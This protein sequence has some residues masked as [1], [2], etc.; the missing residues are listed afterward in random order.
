MNANRAVLLASLLFATIASAQIADLSIRISGA[1]PT[2]E[3]HEKFDYSATLV[4]HGPDDAEHVEVTIGDSGWE[5]CLWPTDIGTLPA[6]AT[7]TFACR[8]EAAYEPYVHELEAVVFSAT[9]DPN[10][11]NNRATSLVYVITPP[12]LEVGILM[13]RLVAPGIGFPVEISYA[14]LSRTAASGV[15]ITVTPQTRVTQV[16]AECEIEGTSATCSVGSIG[17]DEP[18]RRHLVLYVEAP[19]ASQAAFTITA[20]ITAAEEDPVRDNNTRTAS[21]KTFLTT[22][23][24]NIADS[25]SGSLRAAIEWANA[26]CNSAEGCL[27]AFRVPPAGK[28]WQTIRTLTPLPRI[29]G[30]TVRVDGTTQTAYFGDTN[31]AGPEIEV[32]GSA[33]TSGNGF[34]IAA[35]AVLRGLTINGFP[36]SGVFILPDRPG[37]A[38]IEKNYIGTDPTG[39]ISV[40]NQRGVWIEVPD[41]STAR[42]RDNTISG[43][44]RSAVYIQRGQTE[45]LRNIIGLNGTLTAGVGNGASGVYVSPNAGLARIE[46]NYIGFNEHFGIAIAREAT[47]VLAGRNSFQAN[48]QMA[49]DWGFDGLP[50]SDPAPIPEIARVWFAEGVT[51][52]EVTTPELFPS[53]VISPEIVVFA[54][55][56]PDPS[57]FG[58][59]QYFLGSGQIPF[60]KD[61]FV[62]VYPGDLRGKWVTAVATHS[63]WYGFA[64][65]HPSATARALPLG[66]IVTS[67]FSR[68][69]EVK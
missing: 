68:A 21:S 24:E 48:W 60:G 53:S 18:A 43:N 12:D 47:K 57:G 26:S 25:G 32:N 42:V 1:P 30:Q 27:V 22:W 20:R 36:D 17:V 45:V 58:E 40:A 54:N 64:Q 9:D 31:L 23:V 55:D 37:S 63:N 46:E 44:T 2:V 6:F 62:L 11:E 50:T 4:N 29:V 59:G 51:S 8:S 3:P 52:I 10:E 35:D 41:Q 38:T 65:G 49:I 66:T 28:A 34:E 69:V 67:E 13:P 56:A 39:Q 15:T 5:Q 61:R 14:N 16:P 33:L 7:R 19:D